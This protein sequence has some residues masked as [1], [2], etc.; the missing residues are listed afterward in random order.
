VCHD[1]SPTKVANALAGLED[2]HLTERVEA[3][4][5]NRL[6]HKKYFLQVKNM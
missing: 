4:I 5:V 6:S 1:F 3:F 2:L